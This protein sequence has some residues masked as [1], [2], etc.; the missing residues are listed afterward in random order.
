MSIIKYQIDA[1]GIIS[2]IKIIRIIRNLNSLI[3]ELLWGS[4]V[5]R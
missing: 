2:I 3:K 1:Y 5:F 4:T